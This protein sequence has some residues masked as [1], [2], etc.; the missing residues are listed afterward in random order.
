MTALEELLAVVGDA[1]G[2]QA[3]DRLCEACVALFDVDAAAIS[4]IFDGVDIGILGASGTTARELD[5]LQFTVGEGPCLDAVAH[6]IPIFVLDLADPRE[7]SWPAY[8][9]A[10]LAREIRG[11]YAL[12]IVIAGQFV[13]ALDLF[14]NLPGLLAADDLTGV[15]AAAD[16]AQLPFLDFVGTDLETALTDPDSDAWAELDTLS[17]TEVSQATGA[18]VAQLEV[19]PAAA[20]LRLRAHA[21]VTGRSA[22]DIALDILAHRLELEAD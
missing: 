14:R 1:R 3:G 2:A 5:E 20:L 19:A 13:G 16:L 12:P 17:R 6:R 10:L 15:L 18:L 22:T 9:P 7:V 8:R 4:L 11:V 21:Y